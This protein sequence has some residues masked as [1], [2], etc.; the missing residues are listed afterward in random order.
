MTNWGELVFG[1]IPFAVFVL[2]WFWLVHGKNMMN[3]KKQME[4][5]VR[6][7]DRQEEL[8]ERIAVALE[9]REKGWK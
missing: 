1:I 7:M 8:L 5:N 4:R 6:F 3:V 9:Q 2:F